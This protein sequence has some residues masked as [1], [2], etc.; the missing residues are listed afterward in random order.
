M[1]TK[2]QKVTITHMRTRLAESCQQQFHLLRHYHHEYLRAR[3]EGNERSA[4]YYSAASL[5]ARFAAV[6]V[7]DLYLESRGFGYKSHMFK[8]NLRDVRRL[9]RQPQGECS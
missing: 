5:Q 9:D 6:T 4:S 2:K 1:H 3:R 8:Q 7:Y